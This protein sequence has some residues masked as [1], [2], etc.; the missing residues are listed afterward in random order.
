MMRGRPQEVQSSLAAKVTCPKRLCN[1]EECA[2]L[3][4]FLVECGHLDG[5]LIRR[6]GALRMQ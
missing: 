2:Q 5:Q 4:R 1:P 6:D 3:A